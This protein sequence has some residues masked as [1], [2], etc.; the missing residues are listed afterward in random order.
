MKSFPH[1]VGVFVCLCLAGCQ[2]ARS[3]KL[4]RFTAAELHMATMFSITLYA[5]DQKTADQAFQAAFE[6]VAALENVMSDYMAQSELSQ[7]CRQPAGTPVKV[8]RDLYRILEAGLRVA[9]QSGGAFDPTIGPLVRLWRQSRKTHRLPS[10]EE[11]AEAKGRVGYRN[12]E[13]DAQ[14][15]M[16]TLKKPGMQLDLGGNGKGFA[17]DEAIE[18]LK[19][20]GIGSAMVAASGDI[21]LS[22]P[23]PGKTGWE[24]GIASIDHPREGLTSELRLA[25]AGVSTSGDTEQF[26][27]IDGRR[28]SHIVDP[29]TGLGLTN[30]IG[31]TIVAPNATLSD[32]LD[33]TISVLGANRGLKLV[34]SLP[35]VSALIVLLDGSEKK[36]IESPKFGQYRARA[37]VETGQ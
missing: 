17:A 2:T 4:D 12:V 10:A 15:Q 33:T 9:E 30:R 37:K 1:L 16:V 7:L 21:S 27:E 25:H 3:A 19:K 29:V 23:P 14:R 22:D 28:Y 35:G 34:E 11:I 18:V 13:L 32:S 31:V 5:P 6:R 24:I 20:Q 26:V 8:S 36:V